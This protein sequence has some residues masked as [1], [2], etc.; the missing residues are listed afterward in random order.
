MPSENREP[1]ASTPALEGW[2]AR[3]LDY[4]VEGGHPA[5]HVEVKEH[6]ASCL[7]CFRM[8][9]DLGD[10]PELFARVRALSPVETASEHGGEA[11]RASEAPDAA[12]WE[13]LPSQI[14]DA[15]LQS[16]AS[17]GTAQPVARA[18][19]PAA[20]RR[21][22][23]WLALPLT[24]AAAA[25]LIGYVGGARRPLDTSAGTKTAANRPGA[26]R[27]EPHQARLA[28]TGF[29]GAAEEAGLDDAEVDVQERADDESALDEI[30]N[31][32]VPALRSLARSLGRSAL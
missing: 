14:A 28:P 25:A 13:S 23:A 30:A 18:A 19:A 1:T 4:L 9:A 2:C 24:L 15:V 8:R 27:G 31:L 6:L 10:L 17:H 26:A 22:R 32:D 20:P 5:D 12:F 29:N 7:A 16:R 3:T 11:A 21:K